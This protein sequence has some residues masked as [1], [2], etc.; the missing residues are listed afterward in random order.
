MRCRGL[1]K[2]CCGSAAPGLEVL[3]HYGSGVTCWIAGWEQ[4]QPGC[5]WEGCEVGTVSSHKVHLEQTDDSSA[6]GARGHT[7]LAA[8]TGELRS[9]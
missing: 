3:P 1:M 8:N 4:Q 6:G 9:L 5:G 2:G 7:G